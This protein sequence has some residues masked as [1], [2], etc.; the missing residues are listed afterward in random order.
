MDPP[1]GLDPT[2]D[3]AVSGSYTSRCDDEDDGNNY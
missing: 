1:C 2:T 3:C